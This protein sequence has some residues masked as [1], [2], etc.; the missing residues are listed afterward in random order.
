ME[1]WN[2]LAIPAHRRVAHV[3]GYRCRVC[4]HVSEPTPDHDAGPTL[5]SPCAGGG[6]SIPRATAPGLAQAERHF[7]PL[8]G[9]DELAGRAP[10]RAGG[11]P[12]AAELGVQRIDELGQQLVELALIANAQTL[13]QMALTPGSAVDVGVETLGAGGGELKQA[14]TA[15]ARILGAADQPGALELVQAVGHHAGGH[16][17]LSAQRAVGLWTDVQ[18]DEDL[19]LLPGQPHVGETR[20]HLG[21]KLSA[22]LAD[23]GDDSLHRGVDLGPGGE[24]EPDMRI[25]PRLVLGREPASFDRITLDARHRFDSTCTSAS[26]RQSFSQSFC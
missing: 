21:V 16:L 24:G 17:Q 11:S 4:G 2:A 14:P 9:W 23:A 13:Q 8:S 7:E 1:T 12:S 3:L 26:C 18:L 19:E 15:V 22:C 6:Q 5:A 25:Q 10:A 20:P